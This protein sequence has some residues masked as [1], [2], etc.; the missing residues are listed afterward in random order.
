VVRLIYRSLGVK[1]LNC[2]Y[3]TLITVEGTSAF[4]MHNSGTC[5]KEQHVKC[6]FLEAEV[7]KKAAHRD[8]QHTISW[9]FLKVL[10][11]SQRSIVP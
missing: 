11:F 8:W 6:C 7:N 10:E 5:R 1:G 2:V 3:V 4:F 9:Q